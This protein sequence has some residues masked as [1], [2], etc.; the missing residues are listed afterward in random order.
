MK[1]MNKLIAK[2][3]Y[4]ILGFLIISLIIYLRI[5][6]ERL[7]TTLATNLYMH[8]KMLKILFYLFLMGYFIIFFIFLL[9]YVLYFFS[10][11]SYEIKSIIL[12]RITIYNII[13]GLYQPSVFS[14]FL[15]FIFDFLSILPTY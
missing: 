5:I 6:R 4:V 1:K 3:F 8:D 12:L 7:P 11:S 9:L 14:F 2:Y 15:L 10:C 13:Q